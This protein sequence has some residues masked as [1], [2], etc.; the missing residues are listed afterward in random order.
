MKVS[1]AITELQKLN[2]DEEIVI[3]WLTRSIFEDY[4]NDEDPISNDQWASLM[5]HFDKAD[6]YW[7]SNHYAI[8]EEIGL[9]REGQEGND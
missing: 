9:W 4:H 2:P 6:Q 8:E 7:A 5:V 1:T 3:N